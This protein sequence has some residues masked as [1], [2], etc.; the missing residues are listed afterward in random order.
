MN[1]V[2][3]PGQYRMIRLADVV[4]YEF[5]L[6]GD[7]NPVSVKL[8]LTE[9]LGEVT[10]QRITKESQQDLNWWAGYDHALMRMFT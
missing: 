10:E 1:P 4:S 7:D 2:H 8:T 5:D 3:C 6:D 9:G